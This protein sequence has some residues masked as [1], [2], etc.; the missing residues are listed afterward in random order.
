MLKLAAD[1]AE[2]FGTD[3]EVRSDVTKWYPFKDMRCLQQQI[4]VADQ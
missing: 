3:A 4:F 1:P 2:G